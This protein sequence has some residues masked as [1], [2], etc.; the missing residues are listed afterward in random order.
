MKRLGAGK[1]H[2]YEV[3]GGEALDDILIRGALIIE[4]IVTSARIPETVQKRTTRER[5]DSRV[6]G[7]SPV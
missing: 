5:P 6:L 1:V 7:C 2:M 3:K 4:R